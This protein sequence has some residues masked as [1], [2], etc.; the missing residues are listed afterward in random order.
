MSFNLII[1]KQPPYSGRTSHEIL[2][3]IM[4][5]ALFD[6]EHRIVF[7]ETGLTWL[8]ANQKSDHFKSLEKQLKALP[9][10]GSEDI[11]F[12]KDHYEVFEQAPL[13]TDTAKSLE[14][15]E[16]QQWFQDA[17]HVEVF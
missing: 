4:S 10:Y 14:L 5:L 11:F 1:I 9:M 3:A 8:T 17:Q 15:V 12:V 13:L 7:F 16:L 6:I 2:E